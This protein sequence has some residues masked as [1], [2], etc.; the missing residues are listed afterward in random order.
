MDGQ[1]GYFLDVKYRFAITVIAFALAF[2]PCAKVA[3]AWVGSGGPSSSGLAEIVAV[4]D[5]GFASAE[6]PSERLCVKCCNKSKAVVH[7]VEPLAVPYLS[8]HLPASDWF[9]QPDG[10]TGAAVL[11][12]LGARG[13]P[14]PLAGTSYKAIF[15]KTSR[16][17]T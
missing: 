17:L 15:A 13:P 2:L 12:R 3:Y 11:I 8:K 16:F 14:P 7:R 9:K 1:K 6:S 5:I 4:T 10:P